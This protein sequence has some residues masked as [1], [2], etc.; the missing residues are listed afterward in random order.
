MKQGKIKKYIFIN[1]FF[2]S[3]KRELE[4]NEGPIGFILCPTREL[5]QQVFIETKRYAKHYNISFETNL[6][7]YES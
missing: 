2:F 7:K 4:K 1:K 6:Y 3:L 5:A